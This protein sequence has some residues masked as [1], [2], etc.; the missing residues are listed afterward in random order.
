MKIFILIHA[1]ST[2][3]NM[4]TIYY[5]LH[6]YHQSSVF[7]VVLHLFPH[8]SDTHRY[9]FRY[10]LR[11]LLKKL[12]IFRQLK[13]SPFVLL[14]HG[15]FIILLTIYFRHLQSLPKLTLQM[16]DVSG[17]CYEYHY[18]CSYCCDFVLV[19]SINALIS[20]INITAIIFI[21]TT[22]S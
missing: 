5:H 15:I 7:V 16:V 18:C 11:S 1:I 20:T 17:S 21:F 6:Y 9:F 14:I 4:K 10:L 3:V 22:L 12:I 8:F 2:F 13:T 19:I